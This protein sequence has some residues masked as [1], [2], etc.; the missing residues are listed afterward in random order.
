MFFLRGSNSL[1]WGMKNRLAGLKIS[2]SGRTVM[3]A[4]DHGYFQGPTTGLERIDL[5]IA[6]LETDVWNHKALLKVVSHTPIEVEL[7]SKVQAAG[8]WVDVTRRFVPQEQKV[9]TW[10]SYRSPDWSA[11]DKGRRLDH[12]WAS[13]KLAPKISG[14]DI[15]REARGWEKPSD[16]VP[17]IVT[18]G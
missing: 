6:P 5:N 4:V 2:A 14:V 9:F 15:V 12:V 11:A 13:E 17:V 10:W 18:L 3:L 8:P 7:F 1:D 16:H